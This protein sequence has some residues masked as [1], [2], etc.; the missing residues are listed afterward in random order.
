MCASNP[1]K[2]GGS[3]TPLVGAY[4]CT[5]TWAFSGPTCDQQSCHLRINDDCYVLS[6]GPDSWTAGLAKCNQAGGTLAEI[7][8]EF[9]NTNLRNVMTG[10]F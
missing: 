4:S 8:D 5:C 6:S 10:T 9:T 1:C 3:C 7:C 2:H